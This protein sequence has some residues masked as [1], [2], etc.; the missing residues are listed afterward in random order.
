MW[1]YHPPQTFTLLMDLSFTL[2][3][4]DHCSCIQLNSSHN[5]IQLNT[6]KLNEVHNKS[7]PITEVQSKNTCFISV[8]FA[9]VHKKALF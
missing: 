9:V 1:R 4:R 7:P 6:E 2:K 8:D 3:W 5:L